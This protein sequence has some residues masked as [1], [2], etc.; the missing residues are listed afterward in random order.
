LHRSHDSESSI[1]TASFEKE[2]GDCLNSGR[3]GAN[4]HQSLDG[5]AMITETADTR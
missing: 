2:M 1:E 4:Q 3:P 5:G